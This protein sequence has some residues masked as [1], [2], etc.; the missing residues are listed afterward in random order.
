MV[1]VTE[2]ALAFGL[3]RRTL[4]F[5]DGEA[6]AEVTSLMSQPAGGRAGFRA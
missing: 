1:L 3:K 4:H 2:K 6:E 5:T